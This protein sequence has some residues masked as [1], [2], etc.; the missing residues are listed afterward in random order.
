MSVGLTSQLTHSDL[1]ATILGKLIQHLLASKS[2]LE[3]LKG[4]MSRSEVPAGA[5]LDVGDRAIAL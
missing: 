1:M 5:L 2:R 4:L 3:L